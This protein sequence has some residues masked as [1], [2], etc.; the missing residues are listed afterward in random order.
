MTK[1][2]ERA[3]RVEPLA[4]DQR[5][6]LR[7]AVRIGAMAAGAGAVG[8]FAV[9]DALAQRDLFG[10]GAAGGGSDA[11]TVRPASGWVPS[12]G[13]GSPEVTPATFGAGAGAG[14]ASAA[15]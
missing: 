6:S 1:A 8:S 2:R 13:P 3:I 10:R 12:G 14:A 9:K 7:R 11:K 5:W 15:P 4:A